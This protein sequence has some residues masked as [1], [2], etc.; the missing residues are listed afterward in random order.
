MSTAYM[1]FGLV[2]HNI[3][4][5]L[6]LFSLYFK[7]INISEDKSITIVVFC[8]FSSLYRGADT[9]LVRPGRKQA[10]ATKT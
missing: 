7:N 5:K 3:F 8:T 6:F 2:L 9:S 4:Y 10:T 1:L